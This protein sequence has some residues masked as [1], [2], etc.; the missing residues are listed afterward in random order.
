[1]SKLDVISLGLI[2][3]AIIVITLGIIKL[4]TYPGKVAEARKHPQVKAIEVTSLL[5]LIAFPLWMF[6]L[7]WAYS[8]AVIGKLYT[9]PPE[10]E[11]AKL[12]PSAAKTPEPPRAAKTLPAAK[13]G[14]KKPPGATA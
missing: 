2:V 3:F 8:D 9:A 5:G 14:A 7:I 11:P 13:S 4:H 10:D 6:A 12:P 1:M